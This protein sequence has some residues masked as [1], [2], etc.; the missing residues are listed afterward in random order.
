MNQF[1]KGS[2]GSSNGSRARH[3]VLR[4]LA[5]LETLTLEQLREKW[6]DL[7]GREPPPIRDSSS[8]NA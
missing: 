2:Q 6:L 8:S 1:G 7:Y 5:T 3:S 4:Q